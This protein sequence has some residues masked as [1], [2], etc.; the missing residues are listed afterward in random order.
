MLTHTH[1][2]EL[3]LLPK[4]VEA[5]RSSVGRLL[6][7]PSACGLCGYSR[8]REL[9]PITHP[10][11]PPRQKPLQFG[12]TPRKTIF[13]AV[14]CAAVAVANET[15]VNSLEE[16]DRERERPGRGREWEWEREIAGLPIAQVQT[17]C[18]WPQ[19]LRVAVALTL[20][21]SLSRLGSI[22]LLCFYTL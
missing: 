7:R 4:A 13:E 3:S 9:T 10:A 18:H 8:T 22:V 5:M 19:I 12:C 2:H 17:K 21:L 6:L 1:S 20:S 15:R 11:T 16:G 14:Q